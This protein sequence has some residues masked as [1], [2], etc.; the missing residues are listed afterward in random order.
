MLLLLMCY[1]C[2]YIFYSGKNT[3]Q[4]IIRSDHLDFLSN[5]LKKKKIICML[6]DKH[7]NDCCLLGLL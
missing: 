2:Q 4:N 6:F 3:F 1:I 5:I 7:C